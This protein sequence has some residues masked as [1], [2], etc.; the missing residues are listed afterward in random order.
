M[1]LRWS[2]PPLISS[3]TFRFTLFHDSRYFHLRGARQVFC[4]FPAVSSKAATSLSVFIIFIIAGRFISD[5]DIILLA[6]EY[7][8][9]SDILLFIRHESAHVM[10]IAVACQLPRHGGER[11]FRI[12]ER[13]LFMPLLR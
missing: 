12:I 8:L 1:P 6:I 7:H 5:V 13:E 10:R 3:H 2:R 9:R 4:R 11:R